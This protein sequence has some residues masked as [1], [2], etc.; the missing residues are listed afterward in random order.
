M[1][2]MLMHKMHVIDGQYIYL[3]LLKLPPCGFI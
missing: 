3:F 2:L 1:S